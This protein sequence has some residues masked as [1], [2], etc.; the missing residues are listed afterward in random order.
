MCPVQCVTYVSGRSPSSF[1]IFRQLRSLF[2]NL[3]LLA[4]PRFVPTQ[5]YCHCI[6]HVILGRM[7]IAVRHRDGT[8]ASDPR[9]RPYITTG[10][11]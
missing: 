8:V 3:V 2:L 5:K 1:I 7:D 10:G 6:Q 4:V 9:Q 11:A